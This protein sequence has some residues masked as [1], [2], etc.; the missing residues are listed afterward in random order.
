MRRFHSYLLAAGNGTRAGGPKIWRGHEGRS[1]LERQI[2]FLLKLF[3]PENI[4]V[5][6][7]EPWI[8]KCRGFF[9]EIR[10]VAVDPSASPL[11][12][13]HSL[14]KAHPP[15]TAAFLHHIDMPVWERGLFEALSTAL[16]ETAGKRAL[17]PVHQGRRG[18]PVLINA[19][20]T[21]EILALDPKTDRLDRWLRNQPAGEVEVPFSCIHENWNE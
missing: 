2:E 13:L 5:S 11:S 14:L 10:W 6:V 12:S 19:L 21:L 1:L 15:E 20:A 18:H 9:P 7:Q 8:P 16:P 17:I 3:V 4:A